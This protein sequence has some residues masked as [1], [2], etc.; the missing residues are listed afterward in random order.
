MPPNPQRDDRGRPRPGGPQLM[1]APTPDALRRQWG[2]TDAGFYEE[3]QGKQV[4]IGL[5]TLATNVKVVAKSD[6]TFDVKVVPTTYT[7]EIVGV[8][9]FDLIVKLNSGKKT[10]IPK[11]AV[12]FVLQM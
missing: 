12:A 3:C 2:E 11:H 5:V 10:L 9:Q 7:G 6:G 4:V 8:A 1:R